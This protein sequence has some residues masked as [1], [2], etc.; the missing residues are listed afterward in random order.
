[1]HFCP[2]LLYYS[3]RYTKSGS[4][5]DNLRNWYI[6]KRK[7]KVTF[8]HMT[9]HTTCDKERLESHGSD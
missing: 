5:P 1:M 6:Y 9:E 4:D 3:N 8:D 2:Y 7:E